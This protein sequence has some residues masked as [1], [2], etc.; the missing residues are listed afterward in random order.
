VAH[1]HKVC[2]VIILR[3]ISPLFPL[4]IAANRDEHYGR[5]TAP[6]GVI[7]ERPRTIGGRDLDRGGTWMGVRQ[8]GFVVALT[9]QPSD[10]TFMAPRSRGEI[11]MKALRLGHAAA[12]RK[13]LETLELEFYGH[14]NLLFGNAATLLVAHAHAQ[15]TIDEVPTGISV[16][17]NDVLNSKAQPKVARAQQLSQPVETLDDESELFSLLKRILADRHLPGT[18]T[19]RKGPY[20][21][22]L[23]RELQALC[24]RTPTYGT[25]SAIIAALGADAT[26]RLLA[27]D[28]PP[29]QATFSDLVGLF[30]GD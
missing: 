18:E 21:P 12:I 2:T 25:R 29:D 13:Y 20:P 3:D 4:V 23:M 19:I 14:F 17:A 22:A 24:I 28:G 26:R 11:V 6:A 30:S 1:C 5:K 15:L 16:L 27:T 9:N 7:L 8:D 10:P